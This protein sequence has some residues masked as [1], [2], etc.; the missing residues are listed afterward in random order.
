MFMFLTI[1]FASFAAIAVGA[2]IVA[3]GS[4]RQAEAVSLQPERTENLGTQRFFGA[5]AQAPALR[6]TVP[7]EVLMS[8]IEKHVRLEQAAAQSFL[9]VPTRESLHSRTESPFV[10]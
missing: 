7:I 5:D 2:L 6:Q 8:Q 3:S 10:N 9:D 1:L 4:P